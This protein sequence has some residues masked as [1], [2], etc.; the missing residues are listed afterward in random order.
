MTELKQGKFELQRTV[1]LTALKNKTDYL[2]EAD[3]TEKV[4]IN[5]E[6]NFLQFKFIP[7]ETGERK[8]AMTKGAFYFEQSPSGIKPR[9][10]ETRKTNILDSAK[11]AIEIRKRIDAFFNK[12]EVYREEGIENPKRSMLVHSGPGVGKTTII[13]KV[14]NEYVSEHN[15]CVLVWPTDTI[16]ADD[17]QEFLGGDCDWSGVDRFILVMEDLGGGSDIWGSQHQKTP[18]ALLNFLDGIEAVFKKP[19]FIIST[20]NN[21][22]AFQD[23]LVSRPGR[24]DVVLGLTP[25]SKEDRINL[26]KF[27]C[28]DRYKFSG[29]EEN[30]LAKLTEGFSAAHLKEV[31]LRSRIDDKTMFETALEIKKHID[32]VKTSGLSTDKKT[33][34][35]GFGGGDPW[36]DE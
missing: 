13:T 5:G 24:F 34:S 29:S 12:L 30:D 4:T 26:L 10:I 36:N 6:I 15:T 23:N 31:Y 3:L 19:T 20:T 18:A 7:P 35:V 33:S 22:D 1:T 32:K 28:K 9:K 21:A 2:E 25:P 8:F 11:S 14:M 27:F 17:V 16:H